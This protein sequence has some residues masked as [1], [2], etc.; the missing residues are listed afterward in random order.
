[1]LLNLPEIQIDQLQDPLFA[2]KDVEVYLQREDLIHPIIS[3]NKWRKLRYNIEKAQQL[4]KSSILTFG[5]AH[6]NH[7]IATAEACSLAGLKSIGIVRGDEMETETLSNCRKRGMEL[8]F[9]SRE[10]YSMHDSKEY[11]NHY[12]EQFDY[13]YIIPQ[14][15]DNYY[16]TLGCTEILKASHLNPDIIFVGSGTGNTAAGLLISLK[17]NQHLFS[18]P[19]LKGDFMH[20]EIQKSVMNFFQ[21]EEVTEEY[22]N[23]LSVL[24]D[25]HFGGFAK[26]SEILVEFINQF[27]HLHQIQLDPIYTGKMMYALYDQLR[28]NQIPEGSKILA[29]HTGGLQGIPGFEKRYGVRLFV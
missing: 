16:G 11:L 12:Y 15:G 6:S 4:G 24:S 5:G 1:M 13:P 20:E 2:E 26:S 14:G 27:Y 18:V 28:Q 29:I 23:Q 7:L 19:A 8:H 17:E 25:Y 9:V 3:G 22:L 10:E 21:N